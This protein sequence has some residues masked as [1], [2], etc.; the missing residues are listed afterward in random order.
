MSL[1]VHPQHTIATEMPLPPIQS[2]AFLHPSP[3]GQPDSHRRWLVSGQGAELC[4]RLACWAVHPPPALMLEG[5]VVLALSIQPQVQPMYYL[6]NCYGFAL[7]CLLIS[8]HFW[9]GHSLVV[10]PG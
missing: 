6:Y 9:A 1:K 7:G 2:T 3:R 8:A 5:T 4:R 10:P